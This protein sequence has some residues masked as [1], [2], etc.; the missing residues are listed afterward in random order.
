VR[1]ASA[2]IEARADVTA[3][4]ASGRMSAPVTLVAGGRETRLVLSVAVECPAPIV[5]PGADVHIVAVSGSVRAIAPGTAMQPG[6]VGDVVRVRNRVTRS[7]L[8][9]R[10]VD[11]RTV[12]V[13]P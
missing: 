12:E 8:S 3:P 5:A 1:I 11:A 10:I 6:R 4:R 9:A 2:A 13:I 7:Q